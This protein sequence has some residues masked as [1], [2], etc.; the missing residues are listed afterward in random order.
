MMHMEKRYSLIELSEFLFVLKMNYDY[1]PYIDEVMKRIRPSTFD[2]IGRAYCKIQ[3]NEISAMVGLN[4]I[5][6]KME[7]D[8]RGWTVSN[9]HYVTPNSGVS[10]NHTSMHNDDST[11]NPIGIIVDYAS[12]LE[13]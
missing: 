6:T 8:R 1:R 2:L 13:N 4:D 12:F 9:D 10:L 7:I 3:E 11:K 5:E